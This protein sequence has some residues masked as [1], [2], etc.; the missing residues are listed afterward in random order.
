LPQSSL[1]KLPYVLGIYKYLWKKRKKEDR[2]EGKK[3][4]WFKDA[5]LIGP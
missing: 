3:E 5:T 2:K 1:G 4:G